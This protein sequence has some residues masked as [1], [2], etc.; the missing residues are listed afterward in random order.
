LQYYQGLMRNARQLT[1][2]GTVN[3]PKGTIVIPPAE[4]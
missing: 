4:T 1:Q 3:L 2:G